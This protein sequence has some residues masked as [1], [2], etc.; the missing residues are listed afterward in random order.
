MPYIRERK[1]KN[2]EKSYTATVSI[3]GSPEISKTFKRLTDAKEWAHSTE[4][5]IRENIN[6][7][8]RKIQNMIYTHEYV[9]LL[10]MNT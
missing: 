6:F 9:I 4:T 10:I 7:P 8:Q 2:G 3:K 1:R 5:K